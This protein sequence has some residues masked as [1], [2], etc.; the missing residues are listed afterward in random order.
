MNNEFKNFSIN[1]LFPNKKSGHNQF[2]GKFDVNSIFQSE[3]KEY[4]FDSKVLL[5]GINAKREKLKECY[6]VTFKKCCETIE[7]ACKHGFTEIPYEI[8]K[9]S[10]CIGYSCRECI[11]FLKEKL[12]KQNLNIRK[13]NKTTIIISWD[14]LEQKINN[15][16]NNG[17]S[18]NN[19][20]NNNNNSNNN[21]N[22]HLTSLHDLYN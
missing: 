11:G 17:N 13:I 16:N 8:P 7:S 10:E 6:N 18:S 20:N 4:N 3:K 9:Y 22:N 19:S 12:E 15:S 2:V 5:N 14:D 1:N 21:S